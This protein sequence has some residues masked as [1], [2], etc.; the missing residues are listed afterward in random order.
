MTVYLIGRLSINRHKYVTVF[1][2]LQ[3]LNDFVVKYLPLPKRYDTNFNVPLSIDHLSLK[4]SNNIFGRCRIFASDTT[5]KLHLRLDYFNLTVIQCWQK[6]PLKKIKS[7]FTSSCNKTIARQEKVTLNG[8]EIWEE[9]EDYTFLEIRLT[10]TSIVK[11]QCLW[12]GVCSFEIC[13]QNQLLAFARHNHSL[14]FNCLLSRGCAV[15]NALRRI[16]GHMPS[17]CW[18]VHYTV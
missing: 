9:I 12:F 10:K 16:Q 13:S 3:I 7:T 14:S 15:S 5:W 11:S 4:N 18:E 17:S 8:F 2:D 6:R 1:L